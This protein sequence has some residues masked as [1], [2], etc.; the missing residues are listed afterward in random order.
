MTPPPS[1]PTRTSA[2]PRFSLQQ[3]LA[4]LLHVDDEALVR[5]ARDRVGAGRDLR[6]ESDAPAFDL[7]QLDRDRDFFAEKRGPHV[8]PVDFRPDRILARVEVLEQEVPAGVL[9]VADGARGGVHAAVLAHELDD[10]R[11]VDNDFPGVCE[12]GFRAGLHGSP[13]LSACDP[14]GSYPTRARRSAGSANSCFPT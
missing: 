13:R 7:D 10:P 6:L 2:H 9:D 1:I 11:L 12:S 14:R 5:A 8:L 4:H 3:P